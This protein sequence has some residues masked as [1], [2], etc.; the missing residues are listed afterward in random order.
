[1]TDHEFQLKVV[2]RLAA[3]ETGVMEIK[4]DLSEVPEIRITA[5]GAEQRSSTNRWLIWILLLGMFSLM[6]SRFLIGV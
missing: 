4:K 1:M 6:T 2:E 3:I 5:E